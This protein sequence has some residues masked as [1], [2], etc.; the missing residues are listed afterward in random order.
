MSASRATFSAGRILA[1]L[2]GAV[3]LALLACELAGWRF[4]RGPAARAI[5]N[6]AG[7]D[8]VIEA[9]F[10]A[11]LLWN[12]GVQAGRLKVAAASDVDVPH[13]LDA[14]EVEVR[15]G[16][17][18]VW[19]WQQGGPLALR[20]LGAKHLDARL[21]RPDASHASWLI[22]PQD[23]AESRQATARPAFRIDALRVA[24]GV[25]K[26]DDALNDL[27][28]EAKLSLGEGAV[29]NAERGLHV[30]ADGR[31]RDQPVKVDLST[32]S[33]MLLLDTSDNGAAQPVALK[34]DAELGSTHARF[35]GT[36][37]SLLDARALD[38]EAQV[39][40]PSLHVVG[41]PFGVSMPHTPDFDLKGRVT[42][43]SGVWQTTFDAARFGDST[44]AGTLR[45]DSS[46]TPPRL[47]GK[48]SGKRLTL[49]DFGP[50]IGTDTPPPAASD[51]VLPDRPLDL[52]TLQ[53]LD[54]DVQLAID[55]FDFGTPT[56]KPMH[57][58]RGEIIVDQGVLK[59]RSL[60]AQAVGGR[61]TGDIEIDS[62]A[63]PARWHAALR[64]ADFDVG[65]WLR[66]GDAEVGSSNGYLDGDLQAAI[67]VTGYGRSTRNVLGSL[68][69]QA[70]AH[71]RNGSVSHLVMEAIG[72]DLAQALGV[73]IGGDDTLALNCARLQSPI[74]KGVFDPL[75][76]VLDNRDSTIR[77]RGRISLA[78]ETL[79]L[80]I[81]AKPKDVS[82]LSLRSPVLVGG[83]LRHPEVGIEGSELAPQLVAA[84]ALAIVAPIVAWVPLIDLG[85]DEQ[86]DPCKLNAEAGKDES[87]EGEAGKTEAGSTKKEKNA[88]R[89][90]PPPSGPDRR[91]TP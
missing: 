63:Q 86:S 41:E 14:S 22:G 27:T 87:S 72:L 38:G 15:W 35:D 5:S 91:Y 89:R 84:A 16:W 19:R 62:T 82:L 81:E 56:L 61:F 66:V 7:T 75:V 42:H 70:D 50:V 33:I 47:D 6:A 12:P 52:P 23:A 65:Q 49:T 90:L 48:V 51:R 54:V 13:L 37:A 20:M 60:N 24:D 34:I 36:V 39:S 78:D 73:A 88:V 58:L 25:V 77:V 1:V 67:R 46:A 76:A 21:V 43:E 57:E 4:L 71:L 59:V 45:F 68:E 18:D 74:K 44:L 64:V 32:D 69:G 83:T 30:D 80:R 2:A 10:R 40:G 53:A 85:E 29:A 9:P 28:L 26:V 11:H 3:V 79:A 55:T 31:W 8:V 17:L